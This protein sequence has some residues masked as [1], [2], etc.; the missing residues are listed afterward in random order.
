MLA[1]DST[2]L[3]CFWSDQNL[4]QYFG[5]GLGASFLLY[6][7]LLET[8]SDMGGFFYRPNDDGGQ[9]FV[10]S[11]ALPILT[12]PFRSLEFWSPRNYDLNFITFSL[13]GAGT[14]TVVRHALSQT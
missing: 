13:L 8:R 1:T 2:L 4:T 14:Y 10:L 3:E 11:G 6:L 9:S 7:L 5:E 12:Y